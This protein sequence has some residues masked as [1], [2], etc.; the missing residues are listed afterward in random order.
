MLRT[1]HIGD[2]LSQGLHLAENIRRWPSARTAKVNRLYLL[3][4]SAA[5]AI[6][7]ATPGLAHTC[8]AIPDGVPKEADI[9]DHS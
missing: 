2:E 8:I 5:A 6:G 7:T 4:F 3:R 9:D 1:T